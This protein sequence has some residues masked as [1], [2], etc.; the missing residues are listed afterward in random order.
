MVLST[1]ACSMAGEA[2]ERLEVMSLPEPVAWSDIDRWMRMFSRD[3]QAGRIE[4]CLFTAHHLHHQDKILPL[5]YEC[6]VEPHFLGFADNLLSLGYLAEVVES[7]GWEQSSQLVF[8]LG[9]NCSA[10][11]AASRSDSAATRL[12]A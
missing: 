1:V 7:F 5:L 11:G 2:A 6:A 12:I 9:T 4:R 3:G 8:N 10:A